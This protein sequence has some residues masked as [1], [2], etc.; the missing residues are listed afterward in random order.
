[1]P[2]ACRG[3]SLVELL[4][5]IAIIALLAALIAP[6][7]RKARDLSRRAACAGNLHNSGVAVN[8]YASEYQARLPYSSLYSDRNLPWLW[9]L[10]RD[11][12]DNL[13]RF[14][15]ER[16]IAYCPSNPIQNDD[17]LWNFSTHY[18]VTGYF[19]V[20]R[21]TTHQPSLITY[22]GEPNPPS[23]LTRV[24]TSGRA[25]AEAVLGADATLHQNGNYTAI[26]GGWSDLHRSNHLAGAD[27]IGG[28]ILYLDGHVQWRRHGDM[29]LRAS[30]GTV[31]QEF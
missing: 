11:I 22:A 23:Y 7:L 24:D 9:D 28:S 1:M 29:V 25:S 15:Y 12:R 4:V 31:L 26:K 18:V 21:Q 2:R 17:A 3:F 30:C 14:G 10:A 20:M 13:D 27:P 5:V 19:W 16:D 6:S 8:T